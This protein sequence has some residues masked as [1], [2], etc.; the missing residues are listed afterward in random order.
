MA[1]IVGSKYRVWTGSADKTKYGYTKK[2]IVRR[3]QKD[4]SYR[5]VWKRKSEQAKKQFRKNPKVRKAL[6]EQQKKMK[7]K[8]KKTKKKVTKT[9]KKKKTGIVSLFRDLRLF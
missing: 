1:A 8:A 3:K 4:G 2:D 7:D 5:Y 9:K 6:K